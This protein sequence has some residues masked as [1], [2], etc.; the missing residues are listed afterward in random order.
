[1][2][3]IRNARLP[4]LAL[5]A[6]SAWLCSCA[7]ADDLFPAPW[8]GRPDS[9]YAV[10]DSGT[11][12]P[13]QWGEWCE[14]ELNV[15]HF[16]G[17]DGLSAEHQGRSKVFTFQSGNHSRHYL[18]NSDQPRPLKKVR[19]Q[20]TWFLDEEA[21]GAAPSQI[22]VLLADEWP[23]DVEPDFVFPTTPVEQFDHGDGWITSAYDFTLVP[24][25]PEEMFGIYAS[26]EDPLYL[27]QVVIDTW[28]VPEP[29]GIVLL[30]VGVV[31]TLFSV[32]G[33]KRRSR[34]APAAR[35]GLSAF[36]LNRRF[37][38]NTTRTI[39]GTV[40][41][42]VCGLLA[43]SAEAEAGAVPL[44]ANM[45]EVEVSQGLDSVS[46]SQL[47][48][49]S[50]FDDRFIWSLPAPEDL[51]G[52]ATLGSLTV[53]FQADPQVDLN[54]SLT[55]N[56]LNN[57]VFFSISTTPIVFSGIADPQA[58]AAASMTITD[59]AGSPQGVMCT[60]QFANSKSYEA[61]YS[62]MSNVNTQT[63]LASLIPQMSFTGPAAGGSTTDRI[64]AVGLTTVGQPVYM[65]EAE[66][67]FLLS[68]GDQ[69]SGTSTF[70]IIPSTPEPGTL[71]LF[72]L[73]G[74]ALLLGHRHT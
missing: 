7:A 42:L 58:A 32:G 65:M 28:C 6:L 40:V 72:A 13:I 63:I 59:G 37:F 15:P 14:G 36:F 10:W 48:P 17:A 34:G 19:I 31:A 9:V 29:D 69:A 71:L 4:A 62:T 43:V 68:A 45:I 41:A 8:R 49:T 46:F 12:E 67:S 70:V 20:L 52:L 2:N 11:V 47:W 66:Y 16:G 64:P 73:G 5:F 3:A 60:G 25:P 22:G 1:M 23:F 38:I 39:A 26:A 44:Y 18:D 54:F 61:R 56:D 30:G 27:D 51:G 24:N 57:P 74:I 50:V 55:N 53:T 35:R 21:Q 33:S